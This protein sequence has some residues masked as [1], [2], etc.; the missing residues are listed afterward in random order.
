M[1][2]RNM[3]QKE[4]STMPAVAATAPINPFCLYPTYV[5]QLIAIGPGVDSAITVIFIISSCVI[6]CFFDT[7]ESSIRESMAYPPPKVNNPIFENVR[8]RSA[9]RFIFNPALSPCFRTAKQISLVRK[10]FAVWYDYN[11]EQ[12]RLSS[13]KRRTRFLS[14]PK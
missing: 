4:G 12:N 6:H 9:I 5:A 10:Q 7:Q 14:D 2:I 8:K 3:I 13:L 11:I 1:E